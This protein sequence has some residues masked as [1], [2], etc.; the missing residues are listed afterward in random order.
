MSPSTWSVTQQLSSSPYWQAHCSQYTITHWGTT[1]VV[2]L[3][4][5]LLILQLWFR[6]CQIPPTI[7]LTIGSCNRDMWCH[8]SNCTMFFNLS[9]LEDVSQFRSHLLVS[10]SIY[11]LWCLGPKTFTS[12]GSYSSSCSHPCVNP[13]LGSKYV[14]ISI[15]QSGGCVGSIVDFFM[16]APLA[17]HNK[18][19]LSAMYV[20]F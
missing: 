20:L 10:C 2:L 19:R 17:Q 9:L 5:M 3:I 8:W 16:Y 15:M 11:I 13:T 4:S 18:L 7:I 1:L 12:H 6:R 14:L